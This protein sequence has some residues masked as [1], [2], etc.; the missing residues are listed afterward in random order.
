MSKIRGFCRNALESKGFWCHTGPGP[1]PRCHTTDR[2]TP[3]YPH[4]RVPIPTDWLHVY[5][6][7]HGSEAQERSPGFFWI[8]WWT[9]NTD[10]VKT[11]TFLTTF[12]TGQNWRFSENWPWKSAEN[13]QNDENGQFCCFWLFLVDFRTPLE[14]TGFSWFFHV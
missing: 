2:P 6:L 11:D 1:I 5:T 13:R 7:V 3:P 10:L 9:Q 8:Q 12:W 4:T 14:T